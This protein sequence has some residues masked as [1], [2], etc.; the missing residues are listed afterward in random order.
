MTCPFANIYKRYNVNVLTF[1]LS[2]FV[3]LVR[4]VCKNNNFL[5]AFKNGSF[6][7]IRIYTE[8]QLKSAHLSVRKHIAR[9]RRGGIS[10]NLIPRNCTKICRYNYVIEYRRTIVE[11]VTECY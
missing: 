10:L 3:E 11:Y 1:S 9:G 2:V 8:D 6:S 5:S 7:H 4:Q